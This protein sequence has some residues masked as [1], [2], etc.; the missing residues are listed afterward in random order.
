MEGI[1]TEGEG[2]DKVNYKRLGRYNRDIRGITS[3]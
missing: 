3:K 2:E 1:T